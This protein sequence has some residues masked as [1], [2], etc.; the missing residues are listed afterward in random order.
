MSTDLSQQLQ[1]ALDYLQ[2]GQHADCLQLCNRILKHSPGLI[3]ALYLRG[4]AAFQMGDLSLAVN[5]LGIVHRNHPQHLNAAYYFGRA[6]RVAGR[7]E[8][9]LTPLQAALHE[10]N[11]EVHSRY[12]LATCLAQ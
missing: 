11:L 10:K 12:E 7:L 1:Q 8:E 2:S 6:L 3:Q 4:C 9:A 5:D